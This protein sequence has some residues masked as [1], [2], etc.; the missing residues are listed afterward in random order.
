ME[1]TATTSDTTYCANGSEYLTNDEEIIAHGLILSGTSVSGSD[2][3]SVGPFTDSFI[4][5][6][7]M[8]WD[9]MVTIFQ[10]SYAWMYPKPAKKHRDGRMGYRFIYNHYLGP[11]NIYHMADGGGKKLAQ[12]TYTGEKRNCTSEKY[13]TFA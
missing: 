7:S 12:Y 1:S 11:S 3:E 6:R 9:K 4:T 2:H 10:G 8:I 13:D 5:D